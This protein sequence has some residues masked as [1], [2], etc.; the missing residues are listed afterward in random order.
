MG[1]NR[2]INE[3]RPNLGD[4]V[5]GTPEVDMRLHGIRCR[6]LIDTGSQISAISERFYGQHLSNLIL[7][8]CSELLNVEGVGGESLPYLGYVECDVSIPMINN[9]E[10]TKR[11]PLLVVPN[12]K[13]NNVTPCL[14]GTNIL[15]RIPH[16]LPLSLFLPSVQQAVRTMHAHAD[17]PEIS[18]TSMSPFSVQPYSSVTVTAV[19]DNK[20]GHRTGLLEGVA[21]MPV[22]DGIVQIHDGKNVLSVDVANYSDKTL[23]SRRNQV[24]ATVHQ[25]SVGAYKAAEHSTDDEFLN[26][27]RYDHLSEPE[28]NRL[29]SFLARN[30][31]VFAMNSSELGCTDRITHTIELT[32][33]IPIKEKV[34]PIPPAM[35]DEIRKHLEELLSAGIIAESKSPYCSNI[36]VAKKK[37]GSIRLCVDYRKVNAKT[38]KDAYQL[39]RP[40]TLIDCLKGARFYASLDLISGYNQIK[41]HPE[42]QEKSAFSVGSLGF[43]QFQ[44]MPFGLCNSGS[45]FQRLMESVLCGLTM[46]TCLVYIDDI[47]VFAET[48]EELYRRLQEV[49][50]RL[51]SANLTLKPKKCSFFQDHVDFLGFSVSSEGVKC[52]ERHIE[53][54]KTWPIPKDSAEVHSFLGFSGFYRKFV[55][56]YSQIAYPLLKMIKNIS[57]RK[58]TKPVTIPFE[59][60]P[61]QQHAFDS[62]KELLIRAPVLAYPDPEKPYSLHVDACRKGLGAVLYQEVDG[63]M[64]PVAY[65][66]RSLSG[67]EKN[68]TVHKLEFL[69]LKWAI[70]QKF[71]HYLYGV[72]QFTCYTDNNPLVYVTSTAKLDATGLRWVQSLSQ[73][74]FTIKYKPGVSNRDADGLSRRPHPE[75]EQELCT[76]VISEDVLKEL[77]DLVSGDYE[78]C[79]VA[80]ALGLPP[81]VLSNTAQVVMKE[82]NWSREQDL[83]PDLLKVKN[84]IQAGR[85]PNDD[86][87]RDQSPLVLRLL[88]LWDT[89]QIRNG[90]LIKVSQIGD[91]LV[92]RIVI[93][94]H[95][96]KECLYYVHDRMGH[97]GRAKTYGLAKERF[98]WNGLERDVEEKIKHCKRCTCAKRPYLPERAPLV[99]T[100]TSR[101]LEVVFM[102]FVGLE[103]SKG[104]YKYVLVITDHFTKYAAAFPTRNQEAQTVAR[105]LVEQYFTQYGIPE[106]INTDQGASFQGKLMRQ[107]C[108]MLGL[109]KTNTT[110]YH[111]QSDGI[112]ERYNRT[113]INMLRCLEPD[114]K[115][116][117]RSYVNSLTYAYNCTR[118][119]STGHSPFYLMFGRKPRLPIDVF[120]GNDE[121]Y[122]DSVTEIRDRLAA[123]Y[124]TAELAL[125]KSRDRQAR[126]YDRKVRG[127]KLQAG[128]AVLVRNVGLKGKQ[129]LADR[130]QE[131]PFTVL[132][133]PNEDVPVYRVKRGKLIK[134]LHRNLL[135][136]IELPLY[137]TDSDHSHVNSSI[138]TRAKPK[139]M[140]K[141]D[142]SIYAYDDQY[143]DDDND[144]DFS[145]QSNGPILNGMRDDSVPARSPG[146]YSGESRYMPHSESFGQATSPYV[147]CTPEP[148]TPHTPLLQQFDTG[149]MEGTPSRGPEL[150]TYKGA[151]TD[152]GAHS[153]TPHDSMTDTSPQYTE[154]RR[155][156]RTTKRP[157]RYGESVSNRAHV[158]EDWRDRVSILLTLVHLFPG[159][160]H[161][162]CCAI[163]SVISGCM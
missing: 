116:D 43:F 109:E 90:V 92:A 162:I 146:E 64:H 127:Q 95:K 103:V 160:Q 44:R 86:E 16:E 133:Q 78:F 143:E 122:C 129:K 157:E 38:K 68:Y 47:V 63:R 67:A 71:Q 132:D 102:D 12:T 76:K 144:Y 8:Q 163:I 85:K 131:V 128:D 113:L 57:K 17:I 89:L 112:V 59:W 15:A 96:K 27:F 145:V 138:D 94:S 111:P 101:P 104:G 26:S 70:T 121:E 74:N 114:Q 159:Q 10:F 60:G 36:V 54:V 135:L 106:R 84:F 126:N 52:S 83:D 31:K 91:E 154:L 140:H 156:K 53:S 56:G 72:P 40:D 20:H 24:I 2:Q 34:R 13:Y 150:G 39:P 23:V 3:P 65:A 120:L 62:L 9:E 134:T 141:R 22:V 139:A 118:H 45:T 41:M 151:E 158:V 80:E 33:A 110:I 105:I 124:R 14:I 18:V 37:D 55:P 4:L 46:K 97:L 155:S 6:A 1:L 88:Q 66:S 61:E 32:D 69:A 73:Y 123:A 100:V 136:P 153:E 29:K 19:A 149:N 87:K 161:E 99:N 119:D 107:L 130:W 142:A 82:I 108:Q 42:D 35:Y 21:G 75:A 115:D 28:A 51:V 152:P 11:M 5:G 25:V 58:H 49:F 79:G 125:N 48:K 30:R 147:Q 77:C 7:H 93:P 117:W 81:V 98:Y 50:N 148:V 137:A